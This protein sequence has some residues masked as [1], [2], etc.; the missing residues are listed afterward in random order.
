MN[1]KKKIIL[2]IGIVVA[3]I[4]IMVLVS[5]V[6]NKPSKYDDFAKTLESK[7]A[8]FYGAFWCPHCQ[9]QKALFGNFS[10]LSFFGNA[11]VFGS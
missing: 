11:L 2:L 6:S 4:I 3:V 10:N 5:K 1:T 9:A 7:G 8:V